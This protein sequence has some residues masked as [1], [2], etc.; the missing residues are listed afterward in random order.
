L[1]K[2]AIDVCQHIGIPKAH[3][4]VAPC[5]Y[6]F[7]PIAIRLCQ[8]QMLSALDLNHQPLPST[9]KIYDE[10]ADREL[11]RPDATQSSLA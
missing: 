2:H 6:Q 5:F 1:L 9:A 11:A 8:L 7:A 3:N 4:P 10:V